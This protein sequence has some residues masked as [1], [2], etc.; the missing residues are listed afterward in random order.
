MTQLTAADLGSIQIFEALTDDQRD[1]L[2][3]RFEVV[4][5]EPGSYLFRQGEPRTEMTVILEGEVDVVDESGER[6]KVFVTCA[7][8][9][10]LGE[11]LWIED[12]THSVAGL[13][14]RAGRRAVLPALEIRRLRTEQPALF[15]DVVLEVTRLVIHRLRN[16][17]RGER[18][19]GAIVQQGKTRT[20]HDLLGY[21][22]VPEDV[23]WGIQTL[24]ALENFNIT[25]VRLDSFPEWIDSLAEI[26]RSCAVVNG[27]LGLLDQE[28]RDV[29][30]QACDEI[31]NGYWHGHFVVDLVQGGAGTSTNMNANEVIANRA[32]EILGKPKGDYATL[33]PNTH[34]NMAQSTNDVYPSSI[35][36]TLL[37][38][39][40]RLLEEVEALADALERKGDEFAGVIKMGRTQLQDAVPMTLGQ[41]FHAWASNVREGA[42]RV[43][44]TQDRLAVLNM[45]GTAIGTGINTD[46]RYAPMV[47]RELARLTG[48]PLGLAPDLVEE[49]QDTSGFVELAAVFKMLAVRVS[50]ICN[51]LRLLSSGPRCGL[52]EINLPPVQPGSSIMPG[53]VNPVVPE[54]MNQV[55]FQV[56]GLDTTVSMASEAGQLELNVFEPVIAYDLM[57]SIRMLIRAMETLRTNCIDGITANVERCREMV[58]NSIGIVTALNPILGYERSSEVAKEA[59]ETGRSVYELV[60]EKGYMEQD[61]LDRALSPEAMIKPTL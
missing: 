4:P 59:S 31:R 40:A 54:V 13:A 34:V 6:P 39:T 48:L 8:G 18:G 51:D 43:A 15:A 50:K 44:W 32:L 37:K 38:L 28:R 33:H 14:T 20:E 56:I 35:K 53:K 3:P 46:P 11:A 49:T 57:T 19:R 55:A 60:L 22:E 58:L 10:V 5:F 36:I 42:E 2:A 1:L 17:S 52:N 21:R 61:E 29:I 30:V 23:L 12:G 41:E 25:G 7:P 16:A 9:A 27:E 26:K 45:G 24:R 47:V